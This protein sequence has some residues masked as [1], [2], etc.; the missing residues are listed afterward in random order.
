LASGLCAFFVGYVEK[1]FQINASVCYQE[2]QIN[3]GNLGCEALMQHDLPL[4]APS[5]GQGRQAI[6][7]RSL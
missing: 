1:K 4:I 3:A 6:D 2:F 5:R 7:P